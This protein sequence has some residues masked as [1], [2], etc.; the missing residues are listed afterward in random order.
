MDVIFN[1]KKSHSSTS[2]LLTKEIFQVNGQIGLLQIF[3][4]P[5]FVLG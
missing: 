3:Q 5:I 2:S 1:L 4:L